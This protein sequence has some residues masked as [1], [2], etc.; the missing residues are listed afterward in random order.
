MS[1]L[2]EL[3]RAFSHAVLSADAGTPDLPAFV[4]RIPPEAAFRVHQGTVMSGLTNALRLTYPTVYAL[5]GAEFFDHAARAFIETELPTA[6][7]LSA[8]GAGYPAFL[9]V[10]PPASGLRYLADVA[11]LDLAIDRALRARGGAPRRVEIDVRVAMELA[12]TLSVLR[13]DYP[14]DEIRALISGGDTDALGFLDMTPRSRFVAVWRSAGG[15]SVQPLGVV[16]GGFLTA[17]LAGATTDA[18]F[19]S[20]VAETDPDD[21][22]P[23]IRAQVFAASFTTLI[24][25]AKD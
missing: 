13:L 8:Y 16:A 5:V 1:R 17:V 4:G 19:A 10:F 20:A 14:A 18:A 12:P 25:L 7:D 24:P 9:G 3:Q 6:A 22:L 21:T 2:A 11:I 23:E 15:A